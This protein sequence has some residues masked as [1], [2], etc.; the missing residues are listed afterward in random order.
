MGSSNDMSSPYYR[1]ISRISL[2]CLCAVCSLAARAPLTSQKLKGNYYYVNGGGLL[3]MWVCGYGSTVPFKWCWSLWAKRARTKSVHVF[4]VCFYVFFSCF[5]EHFAAFEF[6]TIIGFSY[7][8]PFAST[9]TPINR[10]Y[11][12]KYGEKM[13]ATDCAAHTNSSFSINKGEP[14]QQQN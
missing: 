10:R 3:Q 8:W 5:G 4:V 13:A 7:L 6:R 9:N 12:I 2:C 1:Y 11:S 14:R